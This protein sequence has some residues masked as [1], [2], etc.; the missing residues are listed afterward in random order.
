MIRWQFQLEGFFNALNPQKENPESF[1]MMNNQYDIVFLLARAR[2]HGYQVILNEVSRT[3]LQRNL[4]FGPPETKRVTPDYRLVWGKTLTSF[5]PKLDTGLLLSQVTWRGWDR[6][7]DKLIEE[8]APF[9]LR[10]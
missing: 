10:P 7:A 2:R 1:V 6:K 4:Y 3:N 5:K 8:K 9:T